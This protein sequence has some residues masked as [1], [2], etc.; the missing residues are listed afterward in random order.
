MAKLYNEED[1]DFSDYVDVNT[2]YDDMV[3]GNYIDFDDFR[4]SEME[5][6]LMNLDIYLPFGQ[7]LTMDEFEELERDYPGPDWD[8]VKGKLIDVGN[9]YYKFP[10][11][12]ELTKFLNDFLSERHVP[13]GQ[14][15]EGEAEFPEKYGYYYSDFDEDEYFDY[16]EDDNASLSTMEVIESLENKLS[17]M[18]DSLSKSA[19]LFAMFSSAEAHYKKYLL[20]SVEELNSIQNDIVKKHL[21]STMIEQIESNRTVRL[22]MFKSLHP[23]VE[24]KDIP[25]EPHPKLRNALAHAIVDAK[26]EEGNVNFT[27]K[28][29][30]MSVQLTD[31]IQ[32]I[33]RFV[34]RVDSLLEDV[35]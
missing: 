26:F 19:M 7:Q 32:Q 14:V 30:N 20:K 25:V 11:E 16:G 18:N 22:E 15:F 21:K 17:E 3:Y 24:E 23:G 33:K 6:I 31:V 2:G 34:T 10:N 1:Y 12:N 8:E 4:Q 29:K 27:L 5:S 9:D 13:D 28:G 35:G